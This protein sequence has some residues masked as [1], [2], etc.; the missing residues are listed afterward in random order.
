MKEVALKV[1]NKY[2]EGGDW[3]SCGKEMI[4]TENVSR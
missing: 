3:K 4:F 2:P 1:K